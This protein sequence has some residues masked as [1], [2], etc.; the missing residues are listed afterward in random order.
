MRLRQQFLTKNECYQLGVAMT[1][2]GVMWHSTGADNPRLSRYVPG[3]DFIGY[4]T[5]GSHWDQFRPGGR[6]VCVHAFIGLAADG[7]IATV[8][9]LPWGMKGWHA[10]K[11]K[12]NKTYIGF[13]ICE[14]GLDDPDYFA[15]VYQEAVELTSHLCRLF[16]FDPMQDVL[17]HSEGY[18]KGVAS[19]HGDVMHWFKRHG[20]TMDDARRDVA[21]LLEGDDDMSYDK[22]K[23][24]MKQYEAEKAEQSASEWAKAGLEQAMAKGI[25]DG[26]RPQS[27]ATRQEVALMVNKVV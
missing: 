5:N 26:L 13:E 20:K 24:Y 10:G 8:Q 17:C 2:G 25:T 19:N 7:G 4:N 21:A 27:Y 1:P 22:F 23:E 9:T 6:Q 16:D 15:A 3:D 12:G 11:S 14:D 18:Q